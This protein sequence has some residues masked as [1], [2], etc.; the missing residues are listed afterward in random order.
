MTPFRLLALLTCL[1]FFITSPN[2]YT[3]EA[4]FNPVAFHN[5]V[6]TNNNNT[7]T[8][9]WTVIANGFSLNH[10][11]QNSRVQYFI[12]YDIAHKNLTLA[13]LNNARPVLYPIVQALQR[14]HLPLELA[15]LPAVESGYRL[16]VQSGPGA[17]G[18]WQLLPQTAQEYGV[19][20]DSYWYDGRQDMKVSTYAALNFL[21]DLYNGLDHHWLL[22][23]AAYNSGETTVKNA[24]HHNQSNHLP[25]DYFDLKLPNQT[26]D[27]VPKLLALSEIVAHPEKYGFTLPDIPNKPLVTRVYLTRQINLATAAAFAGTNIDTLDN[28]NSDLLYGIIP[29]QGP[30][31]LYLPTEN[32]ERF[33]LEAKHYSYSQYWHLYEVEPGEFLTTIAKTHQTNVSTLA[34]INNLPSL[35]LQPHQTLIMP[36]STGRV[37]KT[38]LVRPSDTWESFAARNKTDFTA[39]RLINGLDPLMPIRSGTR[40]V[41][42]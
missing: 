26:Q 41:V 8:S 18:L 11:L 23:I 17:M 40:W 20:V 24:I 15:L 28:L 5:P 3:L 13:V 39:L 34:K 37:R 4:N 30:S 16:G 19:T 42:N 1:I 10:E 14:R 27:Y 9:I 6:I 35:I 36:A 12:R 29:N 22:A 31:Y 7:N 25:T 38:D 2:G 33:E 21:A 32:T